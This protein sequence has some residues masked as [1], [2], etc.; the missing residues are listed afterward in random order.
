M[1]RQYTKGLSAQLVFYP[2]EGL[3]DDD[4]A[5]VTILTSSGGVLVEESEVTQAS[6]EA[7]LSAAAA[8]GDA[9]VEVDDV[10]GITRGMRLL[11]VLPSGRR[12]EVVVDGVVEADPGP[13]G[14][15]DLQ[16]GLPLDVPAGA[17]LRAWSLTKTLT[18]EQM[19][20]TRRNARARWRYDVGGIAKQY[21]ETF[22]VVPRPFYI[23][24]TEA[25][26]R[27]EAPD[28]GDF[29][30]VSARWE[31]ALES[32]HEEVDKLLRRNGVYTDRILDR[33]TLKGAVVN[34]FLARLHTIT[35]SPR[36]AEY[37]K[38]MNADIASLTSGINGYD[39]DDSGDVSDGEAKLI[40]GGGI[41][42]RQV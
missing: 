25:D 36:A 11:C 21:E 32:A 6:L 7:T 5:D 8:R 12:C 24:L 15:V 1:P 20:S 38:A 39:Q 26:L 10:T 35:G 40:P 42:M 13:D 9:Q 31:Q 17:K 23:P 3:I 34:C 29:S 27:A 22:D 14:T 4:V 28:W 16:W 30:G 18:A 19:G 33:V 37:T 2:P 41:V